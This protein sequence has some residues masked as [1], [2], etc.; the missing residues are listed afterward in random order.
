[1]PAEA[2][3]ASYLP[4][5]FLIFA[6]ILTAFFGMPI[7]NNRAVPV[8]ARLA[9]AGAITFVI[10]PL[11][12]SKLP[13]LPDTMIPYVLMI[14]QEIVI[15]LMI[16]L[17]VMLVFSALQMAGQIIGLQMGLNLAAVVDPVSAGQQASYVDQFYMLLT[18]LLFLAINGHHSVI[19]ALERSFGVLPLGSFVVT[20]GFTESL[21]VFASSIFVIALRI[22]LPT[23]AAMLLS[24]LA[25][26]IVG[27]VVPQMNVFVVG[28][29][30][31]VGLGFASFMIA[32]PAA[33]ML[34]R[35]S[36]EALPTQVLGLLRLLGQ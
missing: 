20:Q 36:F 5:F 13:P 29:P 4:A 9:I 8:V 2:F 17:A 30:A 10:T 28:L 22:A 25:L 16:A 15:G 34:I 3:A 18:A 23:M 1:M 33:A 32:L 27:R 21:S 14:F 7:F 35:S 19:I 26:L 24:D 12:L 31:K 11:Q 6:R